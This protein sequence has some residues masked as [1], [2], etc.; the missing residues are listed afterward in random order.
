MGLLILIV[1]FALG[2]SFFCSL[3]EATLFSVRLSRLLQQEAAGVRGASRLLEIKQHRVDDAITSI[4]ILN[5]FSNTLGASLAGAQAQRVFQE[6]GVAVFSGILVLLILVGSEVI[7][8]TLGAVYADKLSS[9]VGK[10]LHFLTRAMAPF[11]VIFRAL[12]RLLVRGDSAATSRSDV[13]AVVDLAAQAGALSGDE[14]IL[15]SHMLGATTI[16]V[17]DVM[18]PRTVSAMMPADATLSELL[19]NHEAQAFSRIPLYRENR[20]DVIGYLRQQDLLSLLLQN[21]DLDQSLSDFLRPID[22]I[23]ETATAASALRRFQGRREHI[24][25]VS[26]EHGGIAGLVT[27]EDITETLLGIEII[28]ES[29]RHVD[30]RHL[31]TRLRDERLARLKGRIEAPP[32]EEN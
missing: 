4:L 2:T 27:L 10:A 3:L 29:D 11:L 32:R 16:R 23:P 15:F 8:K 14:S 6:T 18:T 24:A 28:D 9:F 1:A 12:T 30:L 5:T 22:V 13:A 25:V 7:P 19:A 26:D 31:A 17:E 20:D 21:R